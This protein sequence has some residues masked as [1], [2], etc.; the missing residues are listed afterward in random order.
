M[1]VVEEDVAVLFRA[2]NSLTAESWPPSTS[3]AL[4]SIYL[5]SNSTSTNQFIVFQ[6]LSNGKGSISRYLYFM[7]SGFFPLGHIKYAPEVT[8]SDQNA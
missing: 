2:N 1:G 5:S 4:K 3:R 7:E 6:L 8:Y